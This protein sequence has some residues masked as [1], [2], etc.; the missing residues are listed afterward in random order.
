MLGTSGSGKSTLAK[1][2][3]QGMNVPYVEL[4]SL[5]HER[6]WSPAPDEVF[7]ERL[8]NAI[9]GGEWVV[10]GNY[11]RLARDL[12]WPQADHIFWL[13]LPF[14]L[15][16]YRVLKRTLRRC[17][18]REELWNGNRER[19]WPQFFSRD[20][21]LL[22]VITTHWRR[23]R[24]CDELSANPDYAGRVTRLRSGR[25]IAELLKSLAAKERAQGTAEK[26]IR[27]P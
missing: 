22:W 3:A 25:E 21:L 15:V 13:D 12:T 14:A 5:Y 23:R 19:L 7:R 6:N 27:K 17:L 11:H 8:A 9:S 1:R 26:A 24:Q 16:F 4:D 10:D 2:I 18:M 20:S